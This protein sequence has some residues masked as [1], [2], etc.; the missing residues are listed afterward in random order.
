[1][2]LK[3]KSEEPIIYDLKQI[4]L[5]VSSDTDSS[6]SSFETSIPKKRK[7]EI[8]EERY[9][10][11]NEILDKEQKPELEKNN[12]VIPEHIQNFFLKALDILETTTNDQYIV[13]IIDVNSS[14]TLVLPLAEKKIQI[15]DA[16][17]KYKC[18]EGL[19]DTLEDFYE[20]VKNLT[21]KAKK[22]LLTDPKKVYMI[23][24]CNDKEHKELKD[25]CGSCYFCYKN[26]IS[27]DLALN[28][29]EVNGKQEVVR[30]GLNEILCK[31]KYI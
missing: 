12:L 17:E 28:L 14:K 30:K 1:M 26:N 20:H 31:I 9:K 21:D 25:I 16:I 6:D 18:L 7:S 29:I 4:N 5:S 13:K 8:I 24:N 2:S 11:F 27:F 10:M 23:F 15:Y 22:K 19:F 3:R